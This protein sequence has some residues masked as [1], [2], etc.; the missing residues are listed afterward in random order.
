MVSKF[1]YHKETDTYTCPEGQTLAT[2]G[3][4]HQKKRDRNISYNFKKYRTPA[5][6]SCPVKD[7]CTGRQDGRREIERSEYAQAVEKNNENYKS[8]QPLYRKRQEINKHVFGTIKR[9]WGFNL[10]NLRGLEKVNGEMALIMTVYNL[11]RSLNILTMPEILEKL[12]NWTPDYQ[13]VT[14]LYKNRPFL[15]PLQP[16]KKFGLHQAA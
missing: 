14:L 5:C 4:W 7:K 12:K 13:R 10:T 6:T 11:K 2:K 9:Q 3:T 16:R 15:R 8:N 1:I